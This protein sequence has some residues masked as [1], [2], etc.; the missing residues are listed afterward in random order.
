MRFE[1]FVAIRYL[2]GK[3][4]NRFVNLITFI[5]VAGVSVGVMALIVVMAVMEG[6]DRELI[7]TI[8]GNRAHIQVYDYRGNT[9]ADPE[10]VIKRIEAACP[11]IEASAPFTE[12]LT[13][14]Q[15]E[16][17][18]Q[19]DG[20]PASVIG[21]DVDRETAVTQLAENLTRNNGRTLGYGELP[22]K[23]EIVLGYRLAYDLNVRPGDSVWMYTIGQKPSPFG[24]GGAERVLLTVSGISQAQMSEFD[25]FY[26]YISIE[27]ASTIKRI[28]GAEGIHC[29]ITEPFQAER[30]KECIRDTFPQELYAQTWYDTQRSYFNALK[31]EKVVMFIIL[32]FIV[33]VAAFNITSTLIMVVMEKRRDIGI[34]RTLGVSSGSVIRLFV[35]EGLYIG[36]SGTLFGVLFGTILAY[37]LNPV[38]E[39]IA[40]ML[41]VNLYDSQIYYFDRI[42][43]AVVPGDVAIVTVCSVILTFLSTLY[44]AWSASRLA[45]I[46]AL[47][48][49]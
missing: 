14:L 10:D 11:E 26:G 43:S 38:A 22:G 15:R 8:M 49:E 29:K 12:I 7:G 34:L 13:V 39:V 19:D 24:A 20:K 45:P 2:R 41:D 33:L 47:R 30:V 6:F 3:R 36:L 28:K 25:E 31:Q 27:T 16:G 5:S 37:N 48:Y 40:W 35:L 46:D 4:K 18:S 32:L 9:I 23:F 21:V 1:A 42:P 17:T 44:P